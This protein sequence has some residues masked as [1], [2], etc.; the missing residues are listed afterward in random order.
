MGGRKKRER[1]ELKPPTQVLYRIQL[2][3]YLRFCDPIST[4]LPT[5]NFSNVC[6]SRWTPHL[7][8][9]GPARQVR[10]IHG[11]RNLPCFPFP[12][13]LTPLL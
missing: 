10:A 12:P 13:S 4:N 8:Y 11:P 9:T 1:L 2:R 5:T 6:C 3:A 7:W